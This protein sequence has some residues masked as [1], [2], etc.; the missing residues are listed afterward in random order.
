MVSIQEEKHTDYQSNVSYTM[1]SMVVVRLSPHHFGK[2]RGQWRPGGDHIKVMCHM[3]GCKGP[4]QHRP[5]LVNYRWC[6]TE[7]ETAYLN[8][9]Q[10]PQLAWFF[11]GLTIPSVRQSFCSK[12]GTFSHLTSRRC[13][14]S[15]GI[16]VKSSTPDYQ[17]SLPEEW[18]SPTH[19][20]NNLCN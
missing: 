12:D 7:Q 1:D 13:T 5:L 10:E 8:V 9:Q 20:F 4:G 17:N 18:R 6:K 3:H 16:L 15:K 14:N 11:T 19:G 2:V